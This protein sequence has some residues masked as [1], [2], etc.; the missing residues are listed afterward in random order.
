ML[1]NSR[2]PKFLNVLTDKAVRNTVYKL[3]QQPQ[4]YTT[5]SKK[6]TTNSTSLEQS[7]NV[8]LTSGSPTR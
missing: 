1:Y 8:N 2:K 3:L 7:E 5:V 6:F 4:L